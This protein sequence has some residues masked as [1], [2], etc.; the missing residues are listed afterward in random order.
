[1]ASRI[2]RRKSPLTVDPF[3]LRVAKILVQLKPFFLLGMQKPLG[4]FRSHQRRKSTARE[5]FADQVT[6]LISVLSDDE[7]KRLSEED[8]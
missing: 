3:F 5:S 6:S 2:D 4:I 7:S 1:V 8:N